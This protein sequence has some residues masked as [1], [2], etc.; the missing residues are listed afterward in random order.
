VAYAL[1]RVVA[2]VGHPEFVERPQRLWPDAE[3]DLDAAD[4]CASDAILRAPD[5]VYCL[6]S[7]PDLPV[8]RRPP[9]R[10]SACARSS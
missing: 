6:V 7:D 5:R 4:D 3:K 2:E 10:C 8:R 9:G 1:W